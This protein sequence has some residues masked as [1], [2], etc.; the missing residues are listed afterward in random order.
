[1]VAMQLPPAKGV[2]STAYCF[3]GEHWQA[4]T[5]LQILD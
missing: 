5:G 4:L 1:M 3:K 2:S